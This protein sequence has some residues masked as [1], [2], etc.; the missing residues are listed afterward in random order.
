MAG[1]LQG[2]ASLVTGAASG[3][4]RAAA[5]TFGREG[6]RV[7]VADMV[8]DGSKETVKL[9]KAVSYTHLTLTTICSV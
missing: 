7:L 2:K 4:G 9:I 5:L 3:I 8:E 1:L 6:A